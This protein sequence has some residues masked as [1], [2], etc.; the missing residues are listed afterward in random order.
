[1]DGIINGNRLAQELYAIYKPISRQS[2]NVIAGLGIDLAYGF[3]LAGIFLLLCDN[4]PGKSW[5]LKGVSFSLLIWFFRVVM[6]VSSQW[7]MFKIPFPALIYSLCTGL[8]EM[9]VL[10]IIYSVAL[11]RQSAILIGKVVKTE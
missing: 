3:I 9:L 2:I 6:N 10:G 5:F 8:L 7:L 1:M 4:L 11:G